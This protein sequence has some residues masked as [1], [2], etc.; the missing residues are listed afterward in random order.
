M[1]LGFRPCHPVEELVEAVLSGT[2]H[3]R[4]DESRFRMLLRILSMCL[5]LRPLLVRQS[6]E[7]VI[8]DDD[9]Y[10]LL[11]VGEWVKYSLWM[12][13]PGLHTSRIKTHNLAT[14]DFHTPQ[15]DKHPTQDHRKSPKML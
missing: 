10:I 11:Q 13:L 8:S 1:V 15:L 5:Y 12:R 3:Y 14:N 2:Q 7:A 9:D 4:R 6:P